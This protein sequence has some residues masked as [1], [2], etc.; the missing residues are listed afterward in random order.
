MPHSILYTETHCPS[1][2]AKIVVGIKAPAPSVKKVLSP[3]EIAEVKAMFVK[4][5]D[6][7]PFT[8]EKR[9]DLKS[10]VN[11]PDVVVDSEDYQ[12]FVSDNTVLD[13]GI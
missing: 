5:I 1:C 9:T 6:E 8:P 11:D 4:K 3:A 12:N 13:S 10:W 2:Q 7:L